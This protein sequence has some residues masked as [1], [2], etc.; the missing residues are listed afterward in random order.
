MRRGTRR[1][2]GGSRTHK[3]EDRFDFIWREAIENTKSRTRKARGVFLFLR[4]AL[5][6]LIYFSLIPSAYGQSFLAAR[7]VASNPS[8]LP[9]QPA[10]EATLSLLAPLKPQKQREPYVPITP[11]QRVRWFVTNT[12]GPPHLLGGT[13]SAGLGTAFDRPVEYGPH[14]GGFGERYGAWMAGVVPQ[15]AIEA[16]LGYALGE[17]PRYF[18]ARGVPFKNRL[19]N[20]IK[21]TF[22]ARRVDG[23][24]GPAFAR[25][26][27]ISGN[28]FASNA[29]RP[30]SEANVEDALVRTAGAFAGRMAANA[31]EEFSPSV[32]D[33]FSL[34]R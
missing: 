33:H 24:Y 11:R 27:A 34:R 12:F 4:G 22:A 20:V 9:S 18:S 7:S 21:L 3:F 32:R 31:F 30:R 13:I 28:N 10:A 5:L 8:Y 17:D 2:G 29:W 14:W 15:N 19:A 25:Y 23:S 26:A 6:K 1:T 16:G